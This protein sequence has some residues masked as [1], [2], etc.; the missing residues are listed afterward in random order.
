MRVLIIKTRDATIY[1]NEAASVSIISGGVRMSST[2]PFRLV[3]KVFADYDS[4]KRVIR[5]DLGSAVFFMDGINFEYAFKNFK[6]KGKIES[7]MEATL[8][9]EVTF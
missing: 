1:L 9:E 8:G 3:E 6:Y 2:L 5:G 7:I 4:G